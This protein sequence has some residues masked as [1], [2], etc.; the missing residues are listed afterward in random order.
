MSNCKEISLDLVIEKSR[1]KTYFEVPVEIPGNVARLEVSYGYERREWRE[2]GNGDVAVNEINIIDLG[3]RDQSNCFRGASGSERS[4]FYITENEATP[5]YISGEIQPGNWAVVLGAYKIQANGCPLHIDVK[6]TFKEQVLL[7]GD[8]HMHTVNSDG[9]YSV[10]DLLKIARLHGLDYVFLTDHNNYAQNDQIQSSDDLVVM[11]GMEW[12]H[13]KGHANFLGVKRPIERFISNDRETTVRILA[14]AHRNG[15]MVI[16]NHPF[17]RLCP[18]EWGFD[19]PYDAVEI[20]NGPIKEADYDAI[21]WWNERLKEGERIPAVGGSDSHRDEIFR[22]V[23]TPAT[24]VYSPS[25]GSSDILCSLR[26]G[27]SFISYSPDGPIIELSAGSAIMGDVLRDQAVREGR[28]RV[29]KV[30]RGD[31]IRLITDT[32]V[33]W[34]E[35]IGEQAEKSIRFKI[36][37]QKFF[38]AEVWRELMPHFQSLVSISNPLYIG[39]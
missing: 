38:R 2:L 33:E 18:W 25:R 35:T 9:R 36:G 28:L 5:G 20:W 27:H 3:I 26:E 24:F 39:E 13:Y 19:V 1:E 4:S 8:L 12:T 23:G 14:E 34:E 29:R 10:K 16:L 31:K 32:G 15:A 21:Q 7:K 11:P 22:L 6:C 17:C 30:L 37:K